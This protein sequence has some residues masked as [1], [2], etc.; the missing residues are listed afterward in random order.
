MSCSSQSNQN[1]LSDDDSVDS[2]LE[3]YILND[4]NKYITK[5]Y[6]HKTLK[7]YGVSHKINNLQL[8]Q[9]AVTHTSYLE[10]NLIPKKMRRISDKNHYQE[11]G[12]EPAANLDRSRFVPLQKKSYERAEFL[13]D[14]V[15]HLILAEYIYS[16]Y[17]DQ[18]EGFMTTLRT[19]MERD[20]ALANLAIIIGLNEYVLISRI[21]E[22]NGGRKNNTHILEDSF[23]AFMCALFLDAGYEVCKTFLVNLIQNEIDIA[24]LLQHNTNYKDILLRLYH[25]K[26]WKSPEYKTVTEAGPDHK[27]SF[28]M[29]VT[30]NNNNVIGTGSGV[31]KKK[32]EQHA[33]KQA[34]KYL[35]ALADSDDESSEDEDSVNLDNSNYNQENWSDSESN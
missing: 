9:Q 28:V 1:S 29:G 16:R 27:K 24:K 30:D 34:L 6:I 8:Y 11:A 15:I 21:I 5:K 7:T 14:S 10:P 19:R 20:T 23:E 32:G 25:Q 12:L 22:V 4:K 18:N 33:A 35:G 17:Q 3:L 26:K 31:S 2:E 13:G